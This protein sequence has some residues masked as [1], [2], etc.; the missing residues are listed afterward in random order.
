LKEMILEP[1]G[2]RHCYLD[3]GDLITY[4][5]AVG[6]ELVD[7]EL[8]V[9]RPWTL[10]R[11]LYAA[12]GIV[13]NVIDLLQYAQF[14]LGDGCTKN[15]TRLL[16]TETLKTMQTP[17]A[18]IWGEKECMGITWF[19]RD[20]DGVRTIYHEG[21]TNGQIALLLLVPE[22]QFSFA[23]LTNSERGDAVAH[24]VGNWILQQHL[25]LEIPEPTPIQST[26]GELSGYVGRYVQTFAEMELGTLA[27]RLIAQRIPKGG[28]P[29][30]D[31]PVAPPPP[32][33]TLALCEKDRMVIL[34]GE[35]KGGV[36]DFIRRP[37]GSIGWLRS[38]YRIYAHQG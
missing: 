2:L 26:I 30:L 18:T 34:D 15:K 16:K 33:M 32:P 24:K 7:G 19:I 28:F 35:A 27:G 4:R 29:A 20:I 6:H 10:P 12:G 37:D 22:R 9:A 31:S 11:S 36:I 1:L 5:F 13:T 3:P 23:I 14:H 21:G 25:G 8:Q 38:G 17:Q